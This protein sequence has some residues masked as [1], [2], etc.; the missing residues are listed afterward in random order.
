MI[1]R[2]SLRFLQQRAGCTVRTSLYGTYMTESERFELRL[3]REL[4][5]AIDAARGDRSRAAFVKGMLKQ[6]L[7]LLDEPRS[8]PLPSELPVGFA[9]PEKVER[10]P[11]V[12][13]YAAELERLNR[14]QQA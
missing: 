8:N 14:A 9:I 1:S 13:A 10:K 5:D 4:L 6:A 12:D 11:R 3:S 2:G 7:V